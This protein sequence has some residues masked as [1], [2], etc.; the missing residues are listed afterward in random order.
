MQAW[1]L[2]M[3]LQLG[4]RGCVCVGGVMVLIHSYS[5]IQRLYVDADSES[6]TYD[7][8]SHGLMDDKK[9][10]AVICPLLYQALRFTCII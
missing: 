1:C 5:F 8:I 7:H 4:S 3:R 9:T 10:L 2:G 6:G